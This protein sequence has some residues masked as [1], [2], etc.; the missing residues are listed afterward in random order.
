MIAHLLPVIA[1]DT[2]RWGFSGAIQGVKTTW[3]WRIGGLG[4]AGR[5]LGVDA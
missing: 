2:G 1:S 4:F 3:V 5:L